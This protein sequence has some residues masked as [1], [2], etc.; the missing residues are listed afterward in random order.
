V[1]GGLSTNERQL[2]RKARQLLADELGAS[3]GLEPAEAD[4]WIDA[5]LAR[6]PA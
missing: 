2:Y 5:Q 6:T 4:A 3:R 1:T